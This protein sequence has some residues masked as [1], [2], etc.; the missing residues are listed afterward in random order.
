MRKMDTRVLVLLAGLFTEAA[1]AE[2]E[3]ASAQWLV[4]TAPAFRAELAPLI[5]HRRAEGLEVVVV[6]TTNVLTREQ[7]GNA[8]PLEAHIRELFEQTKGPK[9]LLLAGAV[10]ASD[11][12]TAE[13]TVVPALSGTIGRLKEQPTDHGFSLPDKDG[14][15]AV[16]VGRFPARTVAEVRY[17]VQKTL[18]LERDREAGVW[19]NRLVLL[20]GNPGGGPL[21][22]LVVERAT[23]PRLE[24][25]H[26]AWSVQAI[27][28]SAMSRYYLPGT[29]VRDAALRTLAQGAI[30]D[31][32]LGHSAAP[33]MWLEGTNF[34][35]VDDWTKL[36]IPRGQGVFFTCGCFGCQL[37]GTEG[38]GLAAMRN[39]GGPVAVIGASGETWSAPGQ[40]A[41]D[42][43]LRC[44]SKPPFPSQLADYWLG[45]QAGLARG[46]IDD[47][48]FKLYDQFDGSQGKVPLSVQRLEHLEMWMLLGDP[49]LRLPIPPVD[50]S[51]EVAGPV[52]AGRGIT[53]NGVIPGRLVGATVRV[54]L[55]RPLASVPADLEV[56]PPESPDNRPARERTA[57]DNHQRANKVV[58]AT[59]EARLNGN[60]FT[61]AVEVP[62][63]LPWPQVVIRAY[64][65][66]TSES[67]LGVITMPVS[68]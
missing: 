25:L 32:F 56:L 33:S 8:I 48:T 4:V 36:K 39:P 28:N 15:P 52:G 54:C 46:E 10:A 26:P 24:R 21:A 6:V 5:E 60:R 34:I 41:L 17:M 49:A 19:R 11:P 58:L 55:E 2:N 61:C 14:V 43:L 42:G 16:A 12:A 3:H 40:L 50:I 59:A 23:A 67:A 13:Q 57:I 51:L 62:V 65:N 31:V 63:R 18:N 20:V 47:L 45:V 53:V 44:C 1:H 7:I 30:F 37:R 64:A 35:T 66:T 29:H 27:F 22:E 38:Y 9:Y 68:Q